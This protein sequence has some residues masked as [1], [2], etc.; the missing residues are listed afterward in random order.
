M[1]RD[2]STSACRTSGRRLGAVRRRPARRAHRGDGSLGA[3]R[4]GN[5]AEVLGDL[6]LDV[7]RA[8]PSSTRR[9]RAAC[10]AAGSAVRLPPVSSRNRSSSRP[11]TSATTAAAAAPPPARWPAAARPAG[12][13]SRR[14]RAASSS[15]ANVGPTARARS[16]NSRTAGLASASRRSASSAGTASGPSGC[17]TSPVDAQR[18]PAGGEHPHRGQR[19]SSVRDQLGR[20]V[21]QVL[22]VVQHQRG[23]PRGE[24]REHLRA[25]PPPRLG[26]G[27]GPRLGES[28][29]PADV[30]HAEAVQHRGARRRVGDRGELHQPDAVRA[31]ARRRRVAAPGRDLGRQPGL[32][33]TA[34]ADDGDQPGRPAGRADASTSSS[35]PTK[36]VRAAAGSSGAQPARRGRS[37]SRCFSRRAGTGPCRR[38]PPACRG[39]RRRPAPRRAAARR[40]A[41]TEEGDHDPPA[42]GTRRPAP[43]A[44][45]RRRRP[46]PAREAP[47]R[48]PPPASSRTPRCSKRSSAS[49]ARCRR[50][51]LLGERLAAPQPQRLAHRVG[52][53]GQYP[54]DVQPSPFAPAR[55][56]GCRPR[57]RAR[58]EPVAGRSLL[59]PGRAAQRP[60][61][62]ATR[63]CR[64][65]V[66]STGASLAHTASASTSTGTGRPGAIASRASRATRRRPRISTSWSPAVTRRGPR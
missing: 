21:D 43:P 58:D 53:L 22:A 49:P 56:T 42:A 11:A 34:G 19:P 60:P 6:A 12:A 27:L 47:V 52:G 31:R 32:P 2:L 26:A 65:F 13:R 9:P 5:T 18:L 23:S 61:Q 8:G 63:D 36:L 48:T 1:S 7:G 14:R 24:R 15:S 54:A 35:R 57:R 45:R 3:R 44:R 33:G 50:R 20:R 28:P 16:A 46:G 17:S 4:P 39:A 66:G 62:P 40:P 37:T 41:S 25:A 59:D 10:G 51:C 30:A 29:Q 64:L 38:C 55:R